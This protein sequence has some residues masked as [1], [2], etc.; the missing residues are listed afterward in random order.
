MSYDLQASFIAEEF[1]K[2][3]KEPYSSGF[4]SP[5][6][7]EARLDRMNDAYVVATDRAIQKVCE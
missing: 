3:K 6:R 2:D 1:E 4:L 5:N 7:T